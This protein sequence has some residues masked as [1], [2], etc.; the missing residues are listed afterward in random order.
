[1]NR[2]RIL[3]LVDQAAQDLVRDKAKGRGLLHP[4][5]FSEER[6]TFLPPAASALLVILNRNH[7]VCIYLLHLIQTLNMLILY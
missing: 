4:D 3:S 6:L 5:T 1:L 7:N 2:S